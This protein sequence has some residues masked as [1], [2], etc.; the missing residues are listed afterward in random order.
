MNAS[1]R[2]SL[3]SENPHE[4]PRDCRMSLDFYQNARMTMGELRDLVRAR[5]FSWDFLEYH[6][7]EAQRPRSSIDKALDKLDDYSIGIGKTLH[8]KPS[9]VW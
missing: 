9:N 7:R 8:D 2:M 3:P 4:S 1:I 6:I 5:V